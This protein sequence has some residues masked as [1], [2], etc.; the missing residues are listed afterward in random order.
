ME[1]SALFCAAFIFLGE[2]AWRG[3]GRR[4]NTSSGFN[5]VKQMVRECSSRPIQ[6]PAGNLEETLRPLP[7]S[8]QEEGAAFPGLH[9]LHQSSLPAS[10]FSPSLLS[11]KASEHT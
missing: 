8:R 3:A 5:E 7:G 9:A 10:S 11:L 2:G 4:Q 1:S 6:K